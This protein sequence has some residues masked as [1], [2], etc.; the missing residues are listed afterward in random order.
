MPR[1]RTDQ[2]PPDRLAALLGVAVSGAQPGEEL[3]GWVPAR[4]DVELT[5]PPRQPL[6]QPRRQPVGLPLR[7]TSSARGDD[8]GSPASTSRSRGGA[9]FTAS[10]PGGRTGREGLDRRSRP[11]GGDGRHR[12]PAPPRPRL[13]TVPVSLRGASVRPRRTAVLGLLLVLVL[14]TGV[15][16]VRLALARSSATPEPVPVPAAAHG[17][18]AGLQ[19]R[20]VPAAFATAPGAVPGSAPGVAPGVAPGATAGTGTATGPAG[21]VSAAGAAGGTAA[22]PSGVPGTAP[23]V[24][25][26]VVGAVARAGVVRLLPGSRVLDAVTAAGGASLGADLAQLNLARP[27]IDGEQVHVPKKG[28]TLPAGASQAAGPGISGA[29][30]GVG[31]AGGAGAGGPGAGSGGAGVPVDLNSADLAALDTLPGVGPV[32]AQRIV[33]WRTEHGRFSSVDELGEV[34]G[35][36]DKL[37]AQISPKVRV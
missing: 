30:G 35:I 2:P 25:V 26:H 17:P 5:A 33:D 1:R 6:R 3:D 18:P 16:G 4:D 34:S 21:A 12:R 13:L 31:A 23:E 14:V 19:S 37:L 15:L 28:E 8:W 36:G 32:L 24:V 10:T 27:V 29:A 22:P 11:D 20:S 7:Q 9:A